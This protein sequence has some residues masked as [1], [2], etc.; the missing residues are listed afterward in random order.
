[1]H[2]FF[3]LK[4]IPPEALYP[5]DRVVETVSASAGQMSCWPRLPLRGQSPGP[6]ASAFPVIQSLPR[7]GGVIVIPDKGFRGKNFLRPCMSNEIFIPCLRVDD[8]MVIYMILFQQSVSLGIVRALSPRP[9][10]P[11]LAA[12]SASSLFARN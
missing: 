7:L 1:M 9:L 11:V 8:R 3:F 6:A 4:D 2:L 5:L 10:S 12:N